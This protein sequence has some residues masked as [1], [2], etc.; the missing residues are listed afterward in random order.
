MKKCFLLM[1]LG[2]AA[3]CFPTNSYGQGDDDDHGHSDVEFSYDNLG[4]PNTI[5][6]EQ[7]EMTLDN[8]KFFEQEFVSDLGDFF[9]DDPG[10]FTHDFGVNTGDRILLGILN[11]DKNGPGHSDFGVGFVNYY[12]PIS[13]SLMAS[14]SM[15]L[16]AGSDELT[17]TGTSA[18]GDNPLF[19]QAGDGD[20][21]IHKHIFFDLLNDNSAPDGA[22]GLLMQLHADLNVGPGGPN[23]NIDVSSDP[24]W[25]IFNKGMSDTDFDNNALPA[26]GVQAVPEPSSGLL[27]LIGVGCFVARRRRKL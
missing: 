25:L 15:F 23:G 11:A 18:T 14:G 16:D 8:L 22:Y 2:L 24:F 27:F 21:E 10:F 6:V 17:L 20:N 3:C 13:D 1:T 7:D 19:L 4:A 9:S 5:I 26:F 12:D